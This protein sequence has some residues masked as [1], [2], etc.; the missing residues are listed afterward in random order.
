MKK[1]LNSDLLY[2]SHVT[3]DK[4]PRLTYVRDLV[5]KNHSH[6]LFPNPVNSQWMR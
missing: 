4:F 6:F 2:S 5:K 3:L 1:E